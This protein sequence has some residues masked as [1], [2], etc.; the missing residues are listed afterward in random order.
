MTEG[1][2]RG[3]LRRVGGNRAFPGLVIALALSG[4]LA[5]G[6]LA[7]GGSTVL[8]GEKCQDGIWM[9]IPGVTDGAGT[10]GTSKDLIQV[11]SFSWGMEQTGDA[12]V[13][14]KFTIMKSIDKST[15]KLYEALEGGRS[16]EA[17]VTVC[18]SVSAGGQHIK[19]AIVSYH[20]EDALISTINVGTHIESVPPIEDI[21]LSDYG[22]LEEVS[23]VFQKI[24]WD[25]TSIGGAVQALRCGGGYGDWSGCTS[26]T[27]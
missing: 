2:W 10:S 18:D 13:V 5:V 24:T 21:S 4:A 6:G 7:G 23:F 19:E 8:S 26:A 15:P 3:A 25:Q 16:I 12:I 20:M 27:P 11:L 22:H 1:R 14:E 9:G 17:F